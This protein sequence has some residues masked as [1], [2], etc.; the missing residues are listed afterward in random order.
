M[1]KK[2]ASEYLVQS[3]SH[4]MDIFECFLGEDAELGVTNLSRKLELP[5]NNIF[6]LLSTLQCRG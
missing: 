1:T 6:R 2:D 4:A 5:K 3:V